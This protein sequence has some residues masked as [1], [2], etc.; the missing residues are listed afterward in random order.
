MRGEMLKS[1]ERRLISVL[2]FTLTI[3]SLFSSDISWGDYFLE[4]YET[5]GKF[6]LYWNGDDE[7]EPLFSAND[8]QTS[9][10]SIFEDGSLY[11]L[12]SSDQFKKTFNTTRD[13]G[14]FIWRS[15]KLIVRQEIRF[16]APDSLS[17]SFFI[18]NTSENSVKSGIKVLLDTVF[19][20]DARFLFSDNGD[21]MII[22]HEYGLQ[23]TKDFDFCISGPLQNNPSKALMVYPLAYP[24]DRII[25]GNRNRLEKADYAFRV[26]ENWDFSD[27]QNSLD[28]SALMLLFSP[29]DI[30]PGNTTVISFALKAVDP[31]K[32]AETEEASE[33]DLGNIPDREEVPVSEQ[34]GSIESVYETDSP[35]L[36]ETKINFIEESLAKIGQIKSIIDSLTNPG[37]LSVST[38]DR[39]DLMIEELE[40]LSSDES[41]K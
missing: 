37:M 21:K 40:Q 36:M 27:T 41:T 9:H 35:V 7:K 24:P 23:E 18:S 8:P 4:F 26:S 1:N 20:G 12:G 13:G 2:L 30:L 15:K 25:V 10:F 14:F 29:R 5:T 3:S 22:D 17:V 33:E 16:V 28:D 6:R 11:L 38:L 31:E 19:E 39:L 34:E 32:T